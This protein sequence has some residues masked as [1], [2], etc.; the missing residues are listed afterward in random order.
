MLVHVDDII[1]TGTNPD[2]IPRL[3]NSLHASFH[4]KHLGPFTYFLGLEVH[5][6]PQGLFI[7]QQKYIQDL[8]QQA[9]LQNT[10]PID[11]P[12]ELNVKY[13]KEDGEPLSNPTTYR[14]LVSSL[15]SQF[16]HRPTS[17]HFAAVKRIIRNLIGTL[18]QGMQTGQVVQTL[19]DQR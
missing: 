18:E 11:S 19:V 15:V 9:P 14:Q 17:L 16:R 1:I 5:K 6:L 13:S 7:N 10:S 12:L 4:M 2:G 8:I 3:Q